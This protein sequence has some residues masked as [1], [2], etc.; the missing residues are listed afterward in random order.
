MSGA[1]FPSIMAA[2]FMIPMTAGCG[3][4]A[5]PGSPAWVVYRRGGGYIGWFPMPPDEAFLAGD[6]VYRTN[7]D[8]WDRG[9]GYL[10]WYGPRFEPNWLL[11]I[12]VFVD[13]HHFADRDFNRFT[14]RPNELVN[15]LNNTRSVT[16][17]I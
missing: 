2:G 7:W 17:Y 11:S 13:E 15:I 3:S 16:N 10:D 4:R 14:P 1:T 9:D 12:G 5:M 6:E 8:N